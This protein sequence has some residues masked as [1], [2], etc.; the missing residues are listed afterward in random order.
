MVAFAQQ[1]YR[2]FKIPQAANFKC[3]TAYRTVTDDSYKTLGVY[4]AFAEGWHEDETNLRWMGA[5]GT[6]ASLRLLCPREEI[7]VDFSARIRRV[8][9][10]NF[11]TVLLNG[12]PL[13]SGFQDGIIDVGDIILRK[14]MNRLTFK[15]S[16]PPAAPDKSDH[17]LLSFAFSEIAI[18]PAQRNPGW[19]RLFKKKP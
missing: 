10:G 3:L 14:G 16:L 2:D 6:E 5:G 1:L 18:N 13:K 15:S 7:H 9:P 12:I 4:C 11:L 8:L 19:R 17:R